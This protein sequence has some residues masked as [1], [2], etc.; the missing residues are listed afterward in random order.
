MYVQ[1]AFIVSVDL[2]SRWL[3]FPFVA[4]FD[5]VVDCVVDIVAPD[6]GD[7]GVVRVVVV[8]IGVVVDHRCLYHCYVTSP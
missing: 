3:Y 2:F 1:Y 6:V 8:T 4:P 5:Y 7:V